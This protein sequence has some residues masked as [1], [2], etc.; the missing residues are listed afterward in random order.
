MS[1]RAIRGELP[2]DTLEVIILQVDVEGTDEP[3]N[4][5]FSYSHLEYDHNTAAE[6]KNLLVSRLGNALHTMQR[7]VVLTATVAS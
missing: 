1:M 3:Y 5:A 7:K 4:V 2:D 6:F